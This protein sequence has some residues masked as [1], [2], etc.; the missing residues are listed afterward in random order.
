MLLRYLLLLICCWA[1]TACVEQAPLSY[2]AHI[3]PIFNA[4][5][6]G[7]HGGVKQ[8]GGFGLVFR[9]DALVE[10]SSGKRAIVPGKPGQSELLRRIQHEDPE[11]RMPLDGAPLSQE[12]TALISRWIS[13]GAQWE[14]HWAYLPIDRPEV[15]ANTDATTNNPVDVFIRARL[16]KDS[17]APAAAPEKH[18]L[19][20]RLSLDLTGLPPRPEMMRR[21]LEDSDEKAYEKLVDELLASPDF[22]EHW[23]SMWLDLARYADSRGY[24]RDQSRSIWQY[25]DW[26]IRAFND[27]L[28][29]AEFA[30]HQLA[31]D[32][33]PSPTQDQRLAT[34]FHRNT[35]SNDEGGTDN[36]EYRV[37]TVIDR[38][39]TTWEAFLGTTMAC[40]QCHGHP[41]DPLRQEAFYQSY[42]VFNNTADH[43]HVTEAPYLITFHQQEEKKARKLEDWVREH[44]DN[45]ARTQVQGWA[46]MIR[47]R[48]PR[49]RPYQFTE[50]VNGVFTDRGDEDWMFLTNGASLRLPPQNLTAVAALHLNY[51]LNQE[52]R[53]EVRLGSLDGPKVGEALL[54]E[55]GGY[56]YHR[57]RLQPSTGKQALYLRFYG[58]PE[59]RLLG[60][61][62]VLYQE[63]L[64]GATAP[65]Y[66]EIEAF[67]DELLTAKDSVRTPVMAEL[68]PVSRRTTTVFQRGNWL[69]PGDTVTA[70]VAA[71]FSPLEETADPRQNRLAFA[72]W[73]VAPDNPL[74]A[75]VAVNRFW[76]QIFGRGIVQT[77]EDFGSQGAPPTHPELLDWL[78]TTFRDEFAWQPKVLIRLLVT[79][80]TYRQS[81]DLT[82]ELLAQDPHNVLLARAPRKRLAAEQVRDQVLAVS[83]LRSDKMYGPGVM[84]PQPD[85][86]WD[87]VPYSGMRWETSTGEDRYRRAVYTYLRRSVPHPSLTT[88]DGSNRQAC[89]SRRVETNTPLQALMT[90]NDP[91]V[92]ECAVYLA[93]D[94][95]AT[96]EATD[97]R[98]AGLLQRT[99]FRRPTATERERLTALYNEAL[100]DYQ[101]DLSA[102]EALTGAASPELAA[103]TLVV[104]AAFNLDAFLTT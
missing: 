56:N 40:V 1:F 65:G 28:S 80:K 20:R 91:A 66:A 79:S 93:K 42:A 10:T 16:Q 68:A 34:A 92:L 37:V 99:M 9:E 3:R 6:V 18:E 17:L 5:C 49:V 27:N 35:L 12:E 36:E 25:R 8:A 104:N 32:L 13:E 50:V 33:L 23:A 64:P 2:N 61:Y 86:L 4:K 84:P 103:L 69:V 83:G 14:E 89:L 101:N 54:D 55:R 15:P 81:A 41:Y 21:F 77:T 7:C 71:I 47:V 62:G 72:N 39:N 29:Y 73:M 53:V 38:V 78:A 22:G 97:A 74:F 75:R 60:L 57:I 48:E 31:G 11:L 52:T 94:L 100:A 46:D 43:D 96:Y 87:G 59:G 67:I 19:L 58:K 70:G 98:I 85:G 44:T 30:R 95:T 102:A 26:V 51:R 88:F 90:L 45:G 76:A 24:E 82:P 63:A